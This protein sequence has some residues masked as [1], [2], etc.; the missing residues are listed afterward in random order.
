MSNSDNKGTAISNIPGN[1]VIKTEPGLITPG[2]LS[3]FKA[4]RDL[5]LNNLNVNKQQPKKV[6]TP[7]LNVARNKNKQ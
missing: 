1:V 4:P 3:S 2:R 6:F 7:N 5:M